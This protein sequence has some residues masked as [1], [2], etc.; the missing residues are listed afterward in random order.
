MIITS[1][2]NNGSI[3]RNLSDALSEAKINIP[4]RNTQLH[5]KFPKKDKASK[6]TDIT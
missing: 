6:T 5:K 1:T 4:V 2:A 3:I